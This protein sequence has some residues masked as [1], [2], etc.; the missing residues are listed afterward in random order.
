MPVHNWTKVDAGIFHAFHHIWITAIHGTV[1]SLLPPSYYC[2]PEQV[3]GVGNP[4]VLTLQFTSPPNSVPTPN[5]NGPQKSGESGGVA[6]ITAPPKVHF[7]ARSEAVARKP[8]SIVVRHVT[9]HRV[10]AI[11]EVVSP[12]N[13][14]SEAALKS[15]AEKAANFLRS[16]V[17]LLFLDLFPP[18][19]RDPNGIHP[20]IWSQIEEQP[21]TLPSDKPLTLVAYSAGLVLEAFIN[22]VAVGDPLPDMPLFLTPDAHIPVPLEDTYSEAWAKIPSPWREVLQPPPTATS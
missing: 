9:G 5:G 1:S 13:K 16:G 18:S 2:L 15:M 8:K 4:D 21:F 3:A 20:V 17:H 7:T 19:A 22:T 11:I 12:N 6:V 14:A 10:V